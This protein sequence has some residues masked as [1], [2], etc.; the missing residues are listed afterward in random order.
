MI[1][2]ANRIDVASEHAEAFERAFR[3]RAGLVDSTP[4]FV[5][6]QVL[7]PTREGEPYVVLTTWESYD[8]F[9]AWTKSE[10]FRKAHAQAGGT[11]TGGN[12]LEVHQVIQDSA[13]PDL[14]VDPPL[15]LRS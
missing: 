11:P 4:G 13:A 6:N 1:T 14:E 3:E 7:R 15:R 10:A 8:A 9:T 2:V 5:R 12:S